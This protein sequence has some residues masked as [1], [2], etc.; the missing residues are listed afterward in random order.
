VRLFEIYPLGRKKDLS[1]PRH[2]SGAS[3]LHTV[4][5]RSLPPP[6]C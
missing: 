6:A 3:G 4:F 2:T 5:R 1:A